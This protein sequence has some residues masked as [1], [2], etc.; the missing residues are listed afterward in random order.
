LFVVVALRSWLKSLIYIKGHKSHQELVL[1]CYKARS[2]KVPEIK[3]RIEQ[4]LDA[5][6]E[7]AHYVWRIGAHRQAVLTVVEAWS[8]V[9]S[10][11]KIDLVRKVPPADTRRI[12]HPTGSINPYKMVMDICRRL[13]EPNA[14]QKCLNAFTDIDFKRDLESLMAEKSS[15]LHRVHAELLILEEFGRHDHKFVDND[16]YIGCSKGACYF[17]YKWIV[18]HPKNFVSPASHNKVLLGCGGLDQDLNISGATHYQRQ[19]EKVI[20]AVEQDIIRHL[21]SHS[22]VIRHHLSTNGSSRAPST[23]AS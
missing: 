11:K 5:F 15:N 12:E 3:K 16:R 8:Q 10:L 2:T 1:T 23:R 19:L 18:L 14:A 20:G 6:D 7:L 21:D 9:P 13:L 4:P 22:V 17:C